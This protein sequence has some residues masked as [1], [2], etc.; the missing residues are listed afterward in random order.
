MR[1]TIKVGLGFGKKELEQAFALADAG[2]IILIEAGA[3]FFTKKMTIAKN[4]T[5]KGL[6][7]EPQDVV[8][9]GNLQVTGKVKV[10]LHNLTLKNTGDEPALVLEK[11]AKVYSKDSIYQGAGKKNKATCIQLTDSQLFLTACSLYS[12]DCC[13]QGEKYSKIQLNQCLVDAVYLFNSQLKISNTQ[14]RVSLVAANQS[15]VTS[16]DYV[17]FLGENLTRVAIGAYQKTTINLKEIAGPKNHLSGIVEDSHLAIQL[18]EL[19]AHK[20]F[21][22]HHKGSGQV[23]ASGVG[24]QLIN[25]ETLSKKNTGSPVKASRV[26]RADL[27]Q[28]KTASESDGLRALNQLYGLKNIKEQV[29]KLINSVE[30]NR[31]R[32]EKGHNPTPITLHAIFLGNSGTGKTTVARLLGKI[33][34][35]QGVVTTDRFVEVSRQDLVDNVIG[36]TAKKTE[37]I[38]AEARG[39]ILFI[40]EAQTLSSEVERDFGSE[41]INTILQS[42]ENQRGEIM[43]IFAGPTAPMQNFLQLNPGMKSRSFNQFYFADYT[44]AEIAEIGYQALLQEKYQVDEKRYKDIVVHQYAH[45]VD[46]SNARWV[47]NF[48]EKLIL[49]TAD[50]VI[51]SGSDDTDTI[52]ETDLDQITGG[53]R[54]EKAQNVEKLL[55]QLAALTGL[56][57]VKK[58]VTTLIKNAQVDRELAKISPNGE[59]P[60][61][62]MVFEGNPGTGKTTVAKIIAALFYNLDILP[63]PNVKTVERSTLV[64][65]YVGQTEAN[66][67]KA[68]NEAL[69]GV[70]FVDEAYQL[71]N[72]SSHDFGQQVIETMITAL[73]NDRDKFVAIFAGYTE[74]MEEFLDANPG[75]RSRAPKTIVF[76]DYS[77]A[78]IAT[79]VENMISKNWQFDQAFL[80]QAVLEIFEKEAPQEKN[81]NARWARNFSEQLIARHKEYL[82]DQKITGPAMSSIPNQ[83]IEAIYRV[84]LNK[85]D[86]GK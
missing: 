51:A 4:L 81:A 17:E 6:G 49:I 74:P 13:L 53:S 57:N 32:E 79:I 40:D 60:A 12:E 28:K 67:K 64:G 18:V 38:L 62:H 7:D 24:V 43:V 22:I 44:P 48:N 46:Q 39:G 23:E 73:E 1:R 83:V 72:Q 41:A 25:Q 42:M 15:Q 69:G 30:Y 10:A 31:K 84:Y 26:S 45:A 76:P 11:G 50:R 29:R 61:Y 35:Q 68:L 27:H 36:G 85:N 59:K 3:Y 37:K 82:F 52:T 54:S 47:R 34:Y 65:K 77:A 86:P 5:I 20:S 19:A 63:S 78:E 14:V 8:L 56:E 21:T 16:A 70:L 55:A 71:A 80:R 33:L 75:L 58:E 9:E 66:T 2:D